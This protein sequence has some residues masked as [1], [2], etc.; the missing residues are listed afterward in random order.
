MQASAE[1]REQTSAMFEDLVRD[2]LQILLPTT[3][4]VTWGWV[5][6]VV[7]FTPAYVHYAYLA[8][9]LILGT[10][11]LSF[12][13]HGQKL[14]LAIASYLIGLTALVTTI[15]LA[16]HNSSVLYLYLQVILVVAVLTNPRITWLATLLVGG[17]AV[18]I[19]VAYQLPLAALTPP[20]CLILITALTTWLSARR[21]FTALAWALNM[22]I[23]AQKS[24][25]EARPSGGVTAG[26]AES[27]HCLFT[28]RA[29]QPDADLHPGSGGEGLSLQI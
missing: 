22:S 24:A 27:G 12:H 26:F 23:H 11:V 8:L 15:V 18:A 17:L 25:E 19:G 6:F 7:L 28:V 13:L 29:H 21:L 1:Q 9:A 10:G 5:A 4:A 2:T 14:R 16:Y 20:L 3:V